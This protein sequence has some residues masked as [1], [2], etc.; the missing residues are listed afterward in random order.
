MKKISIL[1][2]VIALPFALWSQSKGLISGKVKDKETGEVLPGVNIVIESLNLGTATNGKGE[3]LIKNIPSGKY[4]L[5]V[6]FIGYSVLEKKIELKNSKSLQLNFLLEKQSQNLEQVT[7]IAKSEAREIREQATPVSVITMD[8]IQGTV[9]NVQELLTKTSGIKIRT[10]GGVGSASRISVRGL[11]GKRV[12]FFI[13]DT[14]LSDQSDFIDLND[15]PIDLIERVEVYKGIVPAKFGGS[16]MGGA[17]NIVTKEYPPKY[18]DFSYSLQSYN[19]HNVSAVFKR[20]NKEKGYEYGLGGFYT[21]SDNDY[22]FESP[23]S[24]GLKIKRDHDSFEKKAFAGGFKAK[25][26][27]FDVV[28]LEPFVVFTRKEIQGIEYNIQEAVSYANAYGMANKLEKEDFLTE[29]LDLNFTLVNAF[30]VFKFQDKAMQRY[31]WDGSTYPAVTNLGGE[32]GTNPNDSRNKK[33]TLIQKTNLNYIINENSALNFNAVFNYAHGMPKD[34]LKDRA[35]GHKTNFNSTMN[36]FVSG[37]NYEINFFNRKLTN[38]LTAK[39]YYYNIKTTLVDFYTFARK[40]HDYSKSNFGFSNAIRYRFTPK[41]L[42]KASY[43]YDVRLPSENEL[44]GD[45]FII[46]PAGDLE[47][48]RNKSVNLGLM[49]D[50]TNPNNKRLQL[51]LNVFYME[52]ENMIRFTGGF[53]QSQYQNF[54]QMRTKGIEGDIKWDATSFLYLYAN[55]TYQDL[56]DTRKNEQGSTAPNPTKGD[57]MPNIPYLYANAG[58]EL[59]KENLFGG[60]EQNSKCYFESLFV[61]EY[62]YDFEQSIQQKRRIP[63]ALSFNIGLEHSFKNKN[64]TIGLQVN[65]LTD[66]NLIS[67]F[68]RPLPGRT[69]GIKLRY[70]FR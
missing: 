50:H 5:N 51:E 67:E 52:L 62:F 66:E 15:I 2:F 21:Y 30:T 36:S 48:E 6:S 29:G 57:R 19:T 64:I 68:Q 10:S 28:E 70:I 45:G 60:K 20:N 44:L 23:F 24:P 22:T 31:N 12:G 59:H 42:I 1:I 38:S 55:A 61:E 47:P 17:V 49:Y 58:F 27:W 39:H 46:A 33:Y 7:V 65:N 4:K 40:P 32:I 14:P 41:F 54:G 25:K 43:A 56:R 16:V 37:L 26:W 3:Y 34:D 8:Q 18:A 11:E 9:S 69:A 63:R 53:L 35:V 13:N